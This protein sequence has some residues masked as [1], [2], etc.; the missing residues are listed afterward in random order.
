MPWWSRKTAVSPSSSS[1]SSAASSPRAARSRSRDINFLWSRRSD[2]QRRPSRIPE[3]SHLSDTDARVSS[4]DSSAAG[5]RS[6][7]ETVSRSPSNLDSNP[8]RTCSAP[9]LLPHPLPLPE[10]VSSQAAAS[11]HRESTLAPALGFGL[12]SPNSIGCPL[13]SPREASTRLEGD[14]GSHA[15]IGS[16]V[17]E[18]IQ[19]HERAFS[20]GEVARLPHQPTCRSPERSGISMNGFTFRRQRRMFHDPNSSEPAKFRLNIPAKSAPT[21]GF[22]SPVHSPLCS[23]RRLSNV[24]FSTLSIATPGPQILSASEIQFTDVP[25]FSP[26]TS[27]KKIIISPDLS[28]RYSPTIRSPDLRSRNPSAP[29]SPLHIVMFSDASA[30]RHE[31]GHPLPLPPGAVSPSQSGVSNQNGAKSE[32]LLMTSQWKKGKLIGSGTFGN[33]YEAANRHTGALCA[34][35][36][37]NII[38]DDAKSAESIKQLEQEIN[39]LSQFEHPNIVQYY[40][41]ETIGDRFYIYLEYV[42]PGSIN[43]FVRQYCGATPESVVRS[44][45]RHIL[46]GLAYL[47]SKNIMHRD[48]KGA[49]LLVDAHGVVKLAD[50]GM[51]KHLSGAAGALSLKGSPYWMAPEVMQATMNKDIGYD[52]AVDIWSLG[53][54]IIEMFTGEQPWSGLEGAAAMFKVLHKDPPIP[55]NM[56]NEG[57]DFL[58][59]CFR[60]NPADRPTASKLLEHPFVRHS[61]HYKAHCSLQAFSGTKIIDN[62]ISPRGKSKSKSELPIKGKHSCNGEGSHSH[63]EIS[64]ISRVSHC[65][66]P[67]FVP[68]LSPP[69][70]MSSSAGSSANILNGAVGYRKFPAL[71]TTQAT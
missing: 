44:F 5:P 48:I 45:T 49:N 34:M 54:T 17:V 40:G 2:A 64:E 30:S 29:P 65:S 66:T 53:C 71:Y 61:H 43:K 41:T 63:P 6:S 46:K 15:A 68:C 23:P 51:A 27:P 42:H 37:V 25:V 9:P 60:R 7:S 33:V 16:S 31:N 36:E 24:D 4:F 14:A 28:P 8:G 21:S 69:H 59:C 10:F 55:K 32:A 52:L 18:S 22:S 57:K 26:Q 56:S 13:P 12:L 58:R 62:T 1:P 20:S 38:P 3:L 39:F 50:F 67:E 47:H 35:K 11:P 70:S 19:E